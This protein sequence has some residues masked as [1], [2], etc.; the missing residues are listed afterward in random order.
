MSSSSSTTVYLIGGLECRADSFESGILDSPEDA[1]GST[2]P[3]AEVTGFLE[4]TVNRRFG[5]LSLSEHTRFDSP[6]QTKTASS[7]WSSS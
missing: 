7:S 4:R 1:V 6:S 2:S 3:S 5:D